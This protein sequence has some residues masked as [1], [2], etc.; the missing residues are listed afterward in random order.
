[1]DRSRFLETLADICDTGMTHALSFELRRLNNED[2]ARLTMYL[3][4]LAEESKN[5]IE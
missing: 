2:R 4:S 5:T 1:M 3:R